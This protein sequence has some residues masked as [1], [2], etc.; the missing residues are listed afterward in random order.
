MASIG[1][2]M[3]ILPLKVAMFL[4]GFMKFSAYGVFMHRY[5]TKENDFRS[6]L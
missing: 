5:V 3:T 2:V 6:N 4:L 1:K